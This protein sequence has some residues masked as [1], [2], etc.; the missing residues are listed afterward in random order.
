[1]PEALALQIASRD[2]KD[3]QCRVAKGNSP[4]SRLTL[5]GESEL[6]RCAGVVGIK[7]ICRGSRSGGVSGYSEIL[8]MDARYPAPKP[9]SMLTTAVFGEQEFSMP[10]SAASPPNE[11]P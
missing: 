11:A 9:L 7:R 2:R 3:A 8:I 10:N 5:C 6:P 1:M 4:E